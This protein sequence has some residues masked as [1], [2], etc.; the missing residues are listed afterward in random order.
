MKSIRNGTWGFGLANIPIKM[1]SASETRIIGLDMIDYKPHA[2]IRFLRVNEK[3]GIE[4][5]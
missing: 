2:R 1:Y 4:N 3:T 5:I